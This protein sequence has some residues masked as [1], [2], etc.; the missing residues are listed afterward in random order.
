M[1]KLELST[2]LLHFLSKFLESSSI[3][4]KMEIIKKEIN[5]LRNIAC[6]YVGH[7]YLLKKHI[8][9]DTEVIFECFVVAPKLRFVF[10]NLRDIYFELQKTKFTT[11]SNSARLEDFLKDTDDFLSKSITTVDVELKRNSSKDLSKYKNHINPWPEIKTQ[12]ETTCEQIELMSSNNLKLEEIESILNRTSRTIL[13]NIDLMINFMGERIEQHKISKTTIK[14]LEQ[15]SE[16]P[17]EEVKRSTINLRELEGINKLILNL[18]NELKL[19]VNINGHNLEYKD[20]SFRKMVN[21]WIDDEIMP[22]F[23]EIVELCEECRDE[24][25]MIHSNIENYYKEE[26]R[27]NSKYQLSKNEILHSIESFISKN[28]ES[29]D[30]SNTFKALI[31]AKINA[32]LN[33]NSAYNLQRL[34]FVENS[35]NINFVTKDK[36]ASLF[37]SFTRWYNTRLTPIINKNT[38]QKLH[39]KNDINQQ[40]NEI[41]E[42]RCN[43]P[44]NY[45]SNIFFTKG[46][47]GESF[48]V[49]RRDFEKKLLD[50][51]DSW[52]NGYRGSALII[53]NRHCGKSIFLEMTGKKYF[54]KKLVKFV[55]NQRLIVEGRILE[56]TNDIMEVIAFIDKSIFSTEICFHFDDIEMWQTA[57]FPFG[58]VIEE[59]CYHID[60]N[61]SKHFYMVSMNSECLEYYDPIYHIKKSFQLLLDLSKTKYELLRSMIVKRHLSTHNTIYDSN[62]EEID[63]NTFDNIVKETYY[64]ANG[65]IGDALT[66]WSAL[67]RPNNEG[68]VVYE[69]KIKKTLPNIWDINEKIIIDYLL[70]NRKSNEYLMRK[71]IGPVFTHK[72]QPIVNRLV[73][74]G[75]LHRLTDG[76]LEI[77]EMLVNDIHELMKFRKVNT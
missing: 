41:V 38:I 24:S 27:D 21:G 47:T 58:K 52:N 45:Y 17:F 26:A 69:R 30:S 3:D 25:E 9:E 77:N 7:H 14:V 23:Y 60:K 39:S 68:K 61:A 35:K 64:M 50:L 53:G 62:L 1:T 71:A 76:R 43:Q 54:S 70:L 63:A 49:P 57:E 5:L 75:V 66:W 6:A 10:I 44:K 34:F 55:P 4:D 73:S 29:I 42:E 74:T 40:W 22:V 59:L 16:S 8:D 36:S 56:P 72:Y 33:I 19:P 37:A 11:P 28:Y 32:E 12:I 15:N 67:V 2:S 20:F 48:W 18:P 65:N 51:I 46:L 31:K 13:D